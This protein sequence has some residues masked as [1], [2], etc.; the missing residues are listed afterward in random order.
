MAKR[1]NKWDWVKFLKNA[2]KIGISLLAAG[3]ITSDPE[4]AGLLTMGL[5]LMLNTIEYYYNRRAK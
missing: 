1:I 5:T 3:S 4:L 2:G